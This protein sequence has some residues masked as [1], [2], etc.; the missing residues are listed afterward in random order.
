[1]DIGVLVNNVGQHS[2]MDDFLDVPDLSNHLRDITR[3]NV[4]SIMKVGYVFKS[5]V[6]VTDAF[7]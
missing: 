4:T 3:V 2:P 6:T 7:L 1:M 5:V